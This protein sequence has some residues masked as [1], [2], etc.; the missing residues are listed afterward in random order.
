MKYLLYIIFA[1]GSLISLL[2]F[3]LSFLRY[4]VY[5]L[6][7]KECKW[8][9]GIPLFGSLFL[10]VSLMF[11]YKNL[12]ILILGIALILI[13]TGGILWFVAIMTYYKIRNGR[14]EN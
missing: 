11:L 8:E 4:G 14:N 10:F 9:S 1:M 7:K 12:W 6:L 2:N 13:D 3:Y 5:K